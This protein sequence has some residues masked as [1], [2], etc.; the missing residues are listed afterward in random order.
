MSRYQD[1]L[2]YQAFLAATKYHR[3]N[4]PLSGKI[5]KAYNLDGTYYAADL[6]MGY[7]PSSPDLSQGYIAHMAARC[8][9]VIDTTGE[10][11][12]LGLVTFVGIGM[13]EVSS[14]II[15][16]NITQGLEVGPVSITRGQEIGRFQYGGSTSCLIFEPNNVD[17]NNFVKNVGDDI[18]VGE[19]IYEANPVKNSN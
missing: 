6:E 7:D 8:I 12:D 14:C 10:D 11:T 13:S 18:K 2:V 15:D 5:V 9:I 19:K 1:G 4:S 3:W 16:E 17:I